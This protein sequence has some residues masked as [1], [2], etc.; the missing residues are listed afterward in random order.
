MRLSF[1]SMTGASA[2]RL[3]VLQ[4]AAELRREL[5]AS[6]RTLSSVETAWQLGGR[7][8]TP[9][10]AF[11][12][13]YQAAMR[14]LDPALAADVWAAFCISEAGLRSLR[15]M[16]TRFDVQTSCLSGEKSHVMLTGNGLDCLYVVAACD[17]DLLCVQVAANAPGVEVLSAP[18]V[19]PFLPD[20]P[21]TPVRFNT[22]N[23]TSDY[24]CDQAHQ[25]LNKPFRYWEDV[26]VA[27]AFSG[28]LLA[29]QSAEYATFEP[30]LNGDNHDGA[31]MQA[32]M[33]AADHLA[34]C[35]YTQPQ[36]YSL[37]ALDALE[38]LLVCQDAM[39]P[40]LTADARTVWQR[41]RILL[42][43]AVPLRAKIRTSLMAE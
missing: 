30:S 7:S 8:D 24:R 18:R 19:Q 21:H 1:P 17:D 33:G 36:R 9:G 25:R 3:S 14:Q 34:Q 31:V 41:D 42:Q 12:C 5:A 6:F 11:F 27:L 20:V 29:N 35:F 4:N 37:V 13:G 15:Q 16:Q 2:P 22:V 26:H 32:L 23:I 39:L 40:R 28:W 38:A 10:T 43:L